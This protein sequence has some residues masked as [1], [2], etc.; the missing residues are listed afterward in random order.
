MGLFSKKHSVGKTIATLRKEKGWTQVELAEKLQVSDKA[1]S[2]WEKDDAF[3]SVEFFPALAELF[4]VS[5]DYLMTGKAPEKEVVVMSKA[6]LCA[7]NDDPSMLETINIVIK[8]E[9]NKSIVDYAKQYQSRKVIGAIIQKHG[10]DVLLERRYS[11]TWESKAFADALYYAL[12]TNNL[13]KL[14]NVIG[15]RSR[16]KEEEFYKKISSITEKELATPQYQKIFDLLVCDS[17]IEDEAYHVLFGKRKMDILLN[18]YPVRYC[19]PVWEAGVI[20]LME[21]ALR[22]KKLDYFDQCFAYISKLNEQSF[23]II[24]AAEKELLHY[25]DARREDVRIIKE[26]NSLIP[27]SKNSIKIL[28]EIGDLERAERM[29]L[30]N[31]Q[32]RLSSVE[33]D[34]LRLAKLKASGKV[35]T[36][37]LAVQ[38]TI[39]NG[40]LC[41]DELLS[42]NNF[43]TIKKTLFDYPIHQIEIL[44]KWLQDKNWREL[45]RFAVDNN[46]AQLSD[47]IV[48]ERYEE[49]NRNL[50]KYWQQKN[51]NSKYFSNYATPRSCLDAAET[52]QRCRQRI[53][54]ELALKM[55]K[56][57]T[58]GELTR[59]YFEKLLAKG[60]IEMLIVKL[61]VRLEAILRC[62]YHY[63]GDFVKMIDQYCSTFNTYDD[64]DNN[65]DPHTPRLLHKLR[66]MRNGIVHSEKCNEKLSVSE[67]QE[68]INHICKMG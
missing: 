12:W 41:I 29:H 59:E 31:K 38:A 4:G 17:A 65:Y 1:V 23:P 35:S 42:L 40:I 63:E 24:S 3:P 34:T 64:E 15:E 13:S 21:A 50:L 56:E 22:H 10:F 30:F 51:A 44:A 53:V 57:K 60:D 62:D 14:I 43:K 5:I 67:L 2:K 68:C 28:L 33:D 11:P 55:D 26:K 9:Y 27:V 37:E 45:F 46:D 32:F 19:K 52:L 6:E 61:C 16:N 25:G 58:T 49:V 54:D 47:C 66:M 48:K 36:E 7:K 18:N 8:D 39:H 20:L